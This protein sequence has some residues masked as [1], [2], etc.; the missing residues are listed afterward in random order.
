[1]HSAHAPH[2]LPAESHTNSSGVYHACLPTLALLLRAGLSFPQTLTTAYTVLQGG[3]QAEA[4][5]AALQAACSLA[6]MQPTVESTFG[7]PLMEVRRLG[8]FTLRLSMVQDCPADTH[9]STTL[10]A[11]TASTQLPTAHSTFD[12]SLAGSMRQQSVV[13]RYIDQHAS[14]FAHRRQHRPSSCSTPS[15]LTDSRCTTPAKSPLSTASAGFAAWEQHARPAHGPSIHRQLSSVLGR[16]PTRR[17]SGA[18][19]RTPRSSQRATPPPLSP[20]SVT[21]EHDARVLVAPGGQH[22][23]Q[24]QEA[25]RGADAPRTSDQTGMTH[26]AVYLE[27]QLREQRLTCTSILHEADGMQDDRD[28]FST[29]S[30]SPSP[31]VKEQLSSHYDNAD[32]G[33][34]GTAWDDSSGASEAGVCQPV[35]ASMPYA[36]ALHPACVPRVY[37]EVPHGVICE[38]GPDK[39]PNSLVE[40]AIRRSSFTASAVTDCS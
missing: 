3:P 34:L 11:S 13:H 21:E 22:T 26:D 10:H 18:G 37:P 8:G 19:G 20:H 33:K 38:S 31:F 35:T 15:A 14:S 9:A 40:P 24:Q 30:M 28:A 6:P 29:G 36:G 16:R 17:S 2:T 12:A 32:Q 39:T 25:S 23:A 27:Q 7:L 4:A 5:A 1:M